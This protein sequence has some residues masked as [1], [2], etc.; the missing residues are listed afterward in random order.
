MQASSLFFATR[1][2]LAVPVLVA[3]GLVGIAGCG[4]TE[5]IQPPTDPQ[6]VFLEGALA[7][8]Y[9][10]AA[11]TAQVVTRIRVR[12]RAL[13]DANRA[14]VNLALVVDTSGSMEGRP[15][16]DARA[17]SIAL[18]ETLRVGDRL[19]VVTFGSRTQLLVES[20]EIDSENVSQI[21][22]RIRGMRSEGTTDMAGGLQAGLQEVMRHLDPRGINRLVLLGDGV[23][24]D[25]APIEPLAQ[26]AGE[27][28]IAITALGLGLDYDETLMGAIAQRSGGRFHYLRDSREVA[29]VF[30]DEVLRLERVCARNAALT[31]V[32]GPGVHIDSVVGQ[33]VSTSG[34][35]VLVQLG[36]LSEGASRDVIVRLTAQGRRAG[37]SVELMDAVLAFDDAVADAGRLERRVFLGAKATA[38]DADIAQG[39]DESVERDAAR[40][41]AAAVTIEAIRLARGGE[42][43]R[44]R[45]ALQ[46]AGDEARMRAAAT[47]DAEAT[48][49]AS[50]MSVLSGALPSLAGAPSTQP[51]TSFEDDSA[52][53]PQ[54]GPP[55]AE[56]I[57]SQHGAAMRDIQGD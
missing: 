35:Q 52:P 1:V 2:A 8:R 22:E 6:V 21:R 49:V 43:E 29:A 32:P 40:M 20:T 27:R 57:R 14:P 18:V 37:A 48:S 51:A 54:P 4:G 34:N 16:D 55:A 42:L 25:P 17:A 45:Q 26:A 10:R 38:N 19:A 53:T 11:D 47:G 31:L 5:I 44:A 23:P 24:N 30:R 13:D 46:A 7:N 33:N 28:G 50:R 39:R 12:A 3:V 15:I 9:V 41:Q 36:D 56:I